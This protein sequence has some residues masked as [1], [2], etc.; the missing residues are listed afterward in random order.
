MVTL[1][2]KCLDCQD[3]FGDVVEAYQHQLD[4]STEDEHHGRYEIIQEAQLTDAEK[5][6]LEGRE[7]EDEPDF[8]G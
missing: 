5:A 4:L 2:L 6:N 7:T 1:I 3:L 8:K